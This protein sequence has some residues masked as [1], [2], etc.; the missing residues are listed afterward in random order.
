[1]SEGAAPATRPASRFGKLGGETPWAWALL[2]LVGAGTGLFASLVLYGTKT[3]WLA[4]L[5]AGVLALI[6]TFAL[7][8][9]RPYWLGLFL[10]II[11]FEIKKNLNDGLSIVRAYDIDYALQLHVPAAWQQSRLPRARV[12]L[13]ARRDLPQ[14]EA[15][16]S[17]PPGSPSRIWLWPA[18]PWW[19]RGGLSGHR[20]AGPRSRFLVF[21]LYACNTCAQ[22]V[23]PPDRAAAFAILALQEP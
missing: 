23:A 6:P 16:V 22:E 2:S 8:D 7:R 17:R 14:T 18:L 20:G 3:V 21:F 19:A 13:A 15:Q 9:P 4:L 5:V 1:V 11:Q 12:P 10:F